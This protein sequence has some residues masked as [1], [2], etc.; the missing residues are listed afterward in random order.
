[1]KSI[2]IQ[3]IYENVGNLPT[4]I[5][6][7]TSEGEHIWIGDYDRAPEEIKMLGFE[8]A[9]MKDWTENKQIIFYI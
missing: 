4:V 3:D 8:K 7:I 2:T 5:N 1:M 6:V 9:I